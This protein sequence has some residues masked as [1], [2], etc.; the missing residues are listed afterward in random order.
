MVKLKIVSDGTQ[1]GTKVTTL[2]GEEIGYVQSI[3]IYANKDS[4]VVSAVIL[5]ADVAVETVASG[6][7][8]K[9]SEMDK[10]VETVG[11]EDTCSEC[12]AIKPVGWEYCLT[13]ASK[14]RLYGE[15]HG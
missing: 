14:R 8:L 6:T 4:P 9:E 12:G 13:C 5:V 15:D 1:A 2:D 3:N 11:E 7:I 10:G